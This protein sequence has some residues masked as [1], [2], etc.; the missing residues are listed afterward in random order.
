MDDWEDDRQWRVERLLPFPPPPPTSA[1]PLGRNATSPEIPHSL[2][3]AQR[4]QPFFCSTHC[5][6]HTREQ[7]VE[8]EQGKQAEPPAEHVVDVCT[9]APWRR[10]EERRAVSWP[11]SQQRPPHGSHAR[12]KLFPSA[13]PSS[14]LNSCAAARSCDTSTALF[15]S[16]SSLHC[17]C[18]GVD[19]GR[20]VNV[21][22]C[23]LGSGGYVEEASTRYDEV[24][25]VTVCTTILDTREVE[26]VICPLDGAEGVKAKLI[27]S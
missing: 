14:P 10:S 25:D 23:R 27:P 6:L 17:A 1:H 20:R 24:S 9:A 4:S 7:Q 19:Y 5:A 8:L 18:C 3:S 11:S 15:L 21:C 22:C 2:P 16:T 12:P 26:L 13:N